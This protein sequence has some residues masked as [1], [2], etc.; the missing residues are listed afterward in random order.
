MLLINQQVTEKI[1][2]EIKIFIETNENENSHPKPMG[3]SKSSAKRKIHSNTSL[4]PKN[5]RNIK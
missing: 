4:P 5:K 1:K 3:F 2:K